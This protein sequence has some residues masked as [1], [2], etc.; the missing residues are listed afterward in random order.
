MIATIQR[1][2]KKLRGKF[3]I[4]AGSDRRFCNGKS[5]EKSWESDQLEFGILQR[6]W[7]LGPG[8]TGFSF[9]VPLRKSNDCHNT[10]EGVTWK[11]LLGKF[12]IKGG[13]DRRF[14]NGKSDESDQLEFGIF[15]RVTTYRGGEDPD[16][17]RLIYRIDWKLWSATRKSN[18]CLNTEEGR[19]DW[20]K[21]SV[22]NLRLREEA[23]RDSATE[24]RAKAMYYNLRFSKE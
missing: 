3:G 24:N 10:E 23:I 13:S 4:K 11:K 2:E 18:D 15:Q 9:G 14:C 16:I 6:V 5:G 19:K 20:K 22:V 1:K 12:A 8:T 17:S 7:D 21:N